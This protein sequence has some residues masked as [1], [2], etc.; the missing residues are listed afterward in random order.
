MT[1]EEVAGLVRH[2]VT[3]F[4]GV[5]ISLGYTDSNGLTAIAGGAAAIVGVLWSIWAKRNP[6]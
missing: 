4:G 1:S 5:L 3:T 6:A 2:A